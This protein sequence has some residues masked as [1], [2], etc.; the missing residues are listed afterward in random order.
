MSRT[1]D[2][3]TLRYCGTNAGPPRDSESCK[4][5]APDFSRAS[6]F[7]KTKLLEGGDIA[8]EL[9]SAVVIRF[10]LPMVIL[11]ALIV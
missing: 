2:G 10:V 3:T 11:Q 4:K 5:E 1:V 9:L 6:R 7:Q 8:N